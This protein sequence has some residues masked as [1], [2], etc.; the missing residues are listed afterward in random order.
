MG[1]LPCVFALHHQTSQPL[2]FYIPLPAVFLALVPI[3]DIW[4]TLNQLVFKD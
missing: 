1:G 4:T 2:A 3:E